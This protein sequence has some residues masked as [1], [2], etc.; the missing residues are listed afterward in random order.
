MA[1]FE[2]IANASSLQSDRGY[3]NGL[4]LPGV[5]LKTHPVFQLWLRG[6]LGNVRKKILST[7]L[8]LIHGLSVGSTYRR[9]S[10]ELSEDT[11]VPVESNQLMIY[12]LKTIS[13]IELSLEE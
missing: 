7:S 6:F 12:V 4:N 1:F 9:N 5:V 8:L 10:L 3:A 2:E 11:D 13:V